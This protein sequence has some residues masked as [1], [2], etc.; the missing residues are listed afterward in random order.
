MKA[1]QVLKHYFGYAKFRKGQKEIIQAI[2]KGRDVLA[3]MPTGAGKSICYQVPAMMLEGITIV[4]SPLISLMSDQVKSLKEAGIPA[5]YI[6]SSLTENQIAKALQLALQGAYKIIYAAPER[7]ET[8]RFIYFAQHAEISMVTIDEA[9]CVS[10]WGQDFRPSYV[11]IRRFIDELPE[12][13]VISAFTATA[14]D[15]V[16][17]DIED[18]LELDH[19]F[20]VFTG[21][22][23]P[24]LYY[25]VE[26][27]SSKTDYVIRYIKRNKG[28]S[29]IVYCATR[30]NCDKLFEELA[31]QGIKA[32][33][34]HAGMNH[35]ERKKAQDDFVYDRIQVMIAT[36]AFGMG[37][38]KPDV[39]FVIHYNM[40]SCMENYYQEAGRAGRDGAGS[41]C[42]LLYSPQDVMI[43]KFLLEHKEFADVDPDDAEFIRERD[44]KRLDDMQKYCTTSACLRAYILRYFGEKAEEYCGHCGSC[45]CK[46]VEKDV[47]KE[48]RWIIACMEETGCR[49]GASVIIQTL[50]GSRS[51]RI[52]EIHA[53]KC[54][55]Y[56]RLK[57]QKDPDLRNIIDALESKGYIYRTD[58]RYAVLKTGALVSQLNDP[59]FTVSV[60]I[61]DE[62]KKE[63]A[64]AGRK[65]YTEENDSLFEVL[66]ALRKKLA[67]ENHIPPY[68]VFSDRTL[69]DMC[70][71]RPMSEEEMLQVS[72]VA[73]KKYAKYGKQFIKE[74]RSYEKNH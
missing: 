2:M 48:A 24:E 43:Q 69:T 36:N 51:A 66:K 14:T 65:R 1:E 53:D 32:G 63:T 54:H 23:R 31:V 21:F 72:G 29:G 5:A 52:R 22:D 12:R 11:R 34:Y 58:D 73:E 15:A 60:K 39:R 27:P 56:G 30:K 42:I 49:Y 50:L 20:T 6:N 3:I 26:R 59:D 7:L 62:E 28:K 55:A 41:E 71:K 8:E 64:A 13:P 68:L 16:R 44:R 10:Q 47:T 9:H 40:P 35:I 46:Y 25:A 18:I 4:I 61:K 45:T 74:I 19:P 67:A 38:D 70:M 57:G 33:R 37:I 17:K